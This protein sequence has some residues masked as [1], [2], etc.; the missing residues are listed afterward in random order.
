MIRPQPFA[1]IPG[2]AAFMPWNTPDRLMAMIWSHR[3]FGKFLH[4]R[5]E[6]HAGV[7]HQDVQRT[8][9]PA[10]VSATIAA[11]CSGLLISAPL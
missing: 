6:L 11:I 10:S 4:V 5:D 2:M 3:S 8:Q 9:R 7:V 1:F